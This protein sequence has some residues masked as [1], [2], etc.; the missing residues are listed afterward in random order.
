MTEYTARRANSWA[1]SAYSSVGCAA[2]PVDLH[3]LA[4][5]R[6]VKRLGLRLMVPRGVLVPVQE[7]FE[8]F[9]RD[10]DSRDLDIDA[11]EPRGL[12]SARQ[13]FTFAHEIAHTFFYENPKAVPPPLHG[14]KNPRDLEDLCHSAA[15]RLLVPSNLL[16]NEVRRELGDSE[17]I[18]SGFIRAMVARFQVS[19]DVIIERLRA[20]EIGNC[21][22]RCILLV[23]SNEGKARVITC[24]FGQG[25]S[26]ILPVPKKYEPVIDWFPEFPRLIVQHNGKGR[27]EVTR[28][29]RNLVI[30]KD[31]LGRIGDF[32]LQIDDLDRSAQTSK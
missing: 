31:P 30:E 21:F 25:L 32:L 9:L 14:L 4:R 8:I 23:R 26:P 13:R 16:K 7:G 1:D 27:W 28:N 6:R 15:G 18:D 17:R 19:P 12:L 24:Y 20:V 2:P 10:L 5:H 3:A 11:P 22:S 29:G